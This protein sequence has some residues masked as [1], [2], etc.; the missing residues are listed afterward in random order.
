MHMGFPIDSHVTSFTDLLLDAVC[1]VDADGRFVFVSAACERIFGYT[2]QEMVGKSVAELVAPAD[3]ERTMAAARAVMNGH[4]HIHF[5]NRYVRKDG[6]LVH[7]MWSAR[8]SE[9][10]QVRVAIA[11][12][13]T[14]LKQAQSVQAALYALSE[15]AHACDDLPALFQRSHEII[16]DLLPAAG[17]AV[18]LRDEAGG[19]LRF[20]YR[21]G[22]ERLEE[23]MRLLC[24]TAQERQAPVLLASCA[25]ADGAAPAPGVSM[26]AVPLP[27]GQGS[28]GALVLHS[29]HQGS[30]YSDHERSLLLF[31]AHQLAAAIQRKQL[32]ARMQ[33]MA[34]HDELTLL[35]NRRLFHDRLGTALSRAQRQGARLA[36]LFID[37]NRFKQ[38]NDQHGHLAGDRLL[39][40]VARRIAA[41]V[42]DSDT[43]ARLGGDEFAVLLE[44]LGG[45]ADVVPVVDKIGQAL[46]APFDLGEGLLLAASASIGAAHYP[47]HGASL[48]ELMSRADQD[49]Y[50]VKYAAC[51]NAVRAGMP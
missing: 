4:P 28:L 37:L 11:R 8:W 5:E 49:M 3:R 22:D 41:C 33:F 27:A 23:A 36:L 26:L 6:D 19:A 47:D 34:M 44:N 14:A 17:C 39:Q 29:E 9:T 43:L 15:A 42:R 2:Q 50:G 18:A 30:T 38:V 12:D 10:D 48:Q 31:V 51:S 13:V 7:L 35:P 32:Q 40:Q 24:E 21:A 25:H 45:P 46:S 1:V 16:A 20:A